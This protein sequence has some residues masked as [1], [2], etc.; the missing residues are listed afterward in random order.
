MLKNE[1]KGHKHVNYAPNKVVLP[2]ILKLAWGTELQG[3]QAPF[4]PGEAL[5]HVTLQ[6]LIV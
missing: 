4:I 3:S 1:L 5:G 6:P 2:R